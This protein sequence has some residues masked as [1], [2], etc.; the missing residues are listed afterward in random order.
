VLSTLLATKLYKP[1]PTPNLVARPRLTQRLEEGLRDGHRLFLVVAPAGYGKTTLVSHWLGETDIP[2]A[3]LLLD[4][5]DNDPV[6]F[7]AY[8]VAALQALDP[9]VGQTL[10]D[11]F[12]TIPQSPEALAHPL[13]NDL[14]A[15]NRPII[16]A[17]DDYHVIT[18][19]L[20]HEA[21]SFL[22]DH[23]PPNLHL[24]VLTRAD[25][26]FPLPRLRVR[27]LMTEIRDRDLRFTPEEMTAFLN[28]VHGLNLPAELITALETRTE[29]WPAGVQLAALS[30]QG[31]SAE[32]AAQF[33]QAFS[34]SHHHV[35]DYLAD[36]VLRHQ[37][38]EVQLFLLQTSILER[39]SACLCDAVTGQQG[40]QALLERLEKAN[41]FL[42]PLDDQRRWYR[43]HPLL[44]DL[45]RTRLAQT[46]A[47]LAPALHERASL[48][49]EQ[50]ELGS[51]AVIHA[52]AAGDLE[53]I[54]RLIG[55]RT[56]AMMD[57]AE[58]STLARWLD[59]LP[60]EVVR[61]QPWLCIARAWIHVCSGLFDAALPYLEAAEA[62]QESLAES[63]AGTA[64]SRRLAGYVTTLR[65]YMTSLQGDVGATIRFAQQALA[66]LP[67]VDQATR[68]LVAKDLGVMLRVSGDLPKAGQVLAEAA[69]E[70]RAAG[71]RFATVFLL[72]ELALHQFVQGRLRR[73]Y[74]TCQE[75]L[76]IAEKHRQEVGR[77]LP[78]VSYVY[79]ALSGILR[80]WNDL[81]GAVHYARAGVEFCPQW[82]QVEAL[83]DNQI[84]LALA[85]LAQ[86]DT[87]AALDVI[88]A[89]KQASTSLSSWYM[90]I[91]EQVEVR[92]QLT[93][94][95]QA[96]AERWVR[97]HGLRADAE[98]D[99]ESAP[100]Y[101]LLAR[102]LMLQHRWTEALLL[103]DRL[104]QV[105][106][107]VGAGGSVIEGLVLKSVVLQALGEAERALCCLGEALGRAEPEGHVRTFV[108]EGAPMAGLLQQA[109]AQGIAPGYSDKLLAAFEL[110]TVDERPGP[111]FGAV[112]PPLVEPLSAREL[113]VLHLVAA[114]LSNREIAERLVVAIGTVKKH[115]NN[116]YGKLGVNSRT[117]AMARAR[118]LD[119][120]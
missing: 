61:S 33:I 63:D 75:A 113:E 16:L 73:A 99:F 6:R 12:Q 20:I 26:P 54:V 50:N 60:G 36:E 98:P 39:L 119:L 103:L 48:W 106:E 47:D 70:G 96:A 108:D 117:Q 59:R 92:I 65:A 115:L 32:R 43:Y 71:D 107:A 15:V 4:Q 114:G 22:L 97:E 66:H 111:A 40:S 116:M 90:E 28:S 23:A 11:T 37:P 77:Q 64:E 95:N 34:G 35:I 9:Q 19:G 84:A 67:Q 82:G 1:R 55:G 68:S 5:G 41:L 7:F 89:G 24:V 18:D 104:L 118:D 58:W 81:P 38:E 42:T 30:L 56:L 57:L 85:L 52:L 27:E 46:H 62:G 110:E 45:L 93:L 51:E 2:A 44:A 120:L 72:A 86:R 80:E 17:L 8:I 94:G 100:A 29:G 13:I 101:G 102:T 112:S 10:L 3:W 69:A 78:V 105:Y 88:A 79:P 87:D 31:C 14:A 21:M 25:P 74:A 91:M 49:Y 53:R 109:A 76:G 83:A